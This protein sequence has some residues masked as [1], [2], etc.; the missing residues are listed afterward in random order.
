MATFLESPRFPDTIAFGATVGPTYLTVVN[1]IYSGRDGRIPAWTQSRIRFEVGRRA[2]NAADT[3][4]LDA[5]FRAVKGRAYGFRIKDWTDYTATT[6]NGVLTPAATPGRYQLG[7]FYTTGALNETRS[8][9]KPVAGSPVVYLNASPLAGAAYAVD[10]TT[11]LVTLT[12][13]SFASAGVNGVTV[14]ASTVV[15]LASGIPGLGVGGTLAFNSGFG[16]ADQALLAGQ[17]FQIT[18]LTGTQYTLAVNTTGKAITAGSA[19]GTRYPQGADVLAWAGQF[20][21]P[22]RFDVDEMKK[23]VMD[24]S[25]GDLIVDWGSIPLI[26]IRV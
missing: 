15:T 8:I 17:A 18:A 16:G 25:G 26:E 20:D 6:G 21:V 2:M 19:I 24:R 4:T 7:K 23:Q 5:F 11:G 14:G 10:S 3:A 12:Q 22:V 13:S 9:Q 1:T